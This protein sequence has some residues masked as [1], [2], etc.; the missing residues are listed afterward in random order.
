M[1]RILAASAWIS[2]V[3]GMVATAALVWLQEKLKRRRRMKVARETWKIAM[4]RLGR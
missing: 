3:F 1:W 2:F 4:S